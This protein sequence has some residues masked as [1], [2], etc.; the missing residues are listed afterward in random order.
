MPLELNLFSL[1]FI[2]YIESKIMFYN[3]MNYKSKVKK[4][5]HK[6]KGKSGTRKELSF[7]L[8]ITDSPR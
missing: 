1:L 4:T 2:S 5:V 6:N 8:I 7:G 3:Q